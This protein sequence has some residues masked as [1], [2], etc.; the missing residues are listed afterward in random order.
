M[1]NMQSKVLV[2]KRPLP[3]NNQSICCTTHSLALFDQ[4][5]RQENAGM[6]RRPSAM[7]MMYPDEE[8]RMA[9]LNDFRTGGVIPA[10][11][12]FNAPLLLQPTGAPA[13]ERS[14][15]SV[16]S[17]GVVIDTVKQAEDSRAI[18]V[19]LYESHGA[20]GQ[21]RLTSPL[22]VRKVTRCNFLEE[23]AAPLAWRNGRV[24]FAVRPFQIVTLKLV[25]D[26]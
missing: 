2:E 9:G 17:P 1:I 24:T 7:V 3:G 6:E 18:I 8:S 21:I 22:P 23:D 26:Q 12:A 15:F 19:R 10:A 4:F 14:F 25:L 5:A 11:R 13:A 16:N 20:R